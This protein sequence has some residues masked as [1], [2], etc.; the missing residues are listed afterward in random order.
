MNQWA[1]WVGSHL[2]SLF[3]P[4][5]SH[6][7]RPGLEYINYFPCVECLLLLE[8]QARGRYASYSR[9]CLVTPERGLPTDRC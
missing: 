8:E 5:A 7:V 2:W 6:C 3:E 9:A 4:I 1:P